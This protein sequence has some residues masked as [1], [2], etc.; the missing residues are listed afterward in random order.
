MVTTAQDYFS[1]LVRALH[2]GPPAYALLPSPDNI[3]NIDIS[4]RTIE[5]PKFVGVTRDHKAESIYFIVDRYA[6][7]MDL[8][9]TS[10][11]IHYINANG[12]SRIYHVPFY[13]I[14]KYARENKMIFPWV[15]D[16][17][18]AAVAGPIQFSVQFYK[19]GEMIDDKG[20]ANKVI[21]YSLNTLP[22]KSEVKQSLEVD[23]DGQDS[24]YLLS[25]DQFSQ[26]EAEI[27][28][29]DDIISREYVLRW[30]NLG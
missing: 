7:Y 2:D 13:D 15:I 19:I 16:A 6:D 4:S 10:C 11:L 21:S 1:N 26:I 22:A 12:D 20:I 27:D 29:I 28:R 3:Y 14:Y 5:A 8:A 25:A 18:V 17:Q 24:D 23:K 30:T 9:T